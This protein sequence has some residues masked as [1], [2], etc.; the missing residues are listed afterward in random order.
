MKTFPSQ[1][2]STHGVAL[3]IVLS[4]IV[5]LAALV[6][7]FMSSVM[8]ER[9]A[10]NVASGGIAARQISESTV[11]L[12]M[13]QIREATTQTNE[14]VT[15]ASQPGAIRTFGN[16]IGIKKG[17]SFDY[18]PNINTDFVYKLYSSDRL[19]AP[20]SQYRGI[21]N[22][23]LSKEKAIINNWKRNDPAVGHVDLNE[24]LMMPMGGNLVEPR[25]PI[26]DPM[27]KANLNGDLK[28]SA[29]PGGFSAPADTSMGVVDGFDFKTVGNIDATLQMQVKNPKSGVTNTKPVAYLPMPVRWLYLRKDGSF[30]PQKDDGTIDG[31]SSLTDDTNPIVGRTAFWTDDESC[32]LNI[33]TASEGVFWDTPSVSSRYESGEL[34]TPQTQLQV[35]YLKNALDLGAI[36]PV[37]G[38]F[39]RY[40]GHP[41]TT[42]LSPVLGWLWLNNGAEA[43]HSYRDKNDLPYVAFKEAIY[44]ISPFAPIYRNINIITQ[45]GITRSRRTSRGGSLNVNKLDASFPDSLK[46]ENSNP[47]TQVPLLDTPTSHLYSDVDELLFNSKRFTGAGITTT[48][49]NPPAPN[50]FVPLTPSA[51]ERTRF[52]LTAN[53]RAPEVTLQGRPRVTIWPVYKDPAAPDD[54]SKQTTFDQLFAFTSTLR[55]GTN[56][57]LPFYFTRHNNKSMTDDFEKSSDNKRLFSYLR[58]ATSNRVPG[59]SSS[60]SKTFL[61]KY[62]PQKNRDQILVCIFDYIRTV[63]LVD[64]S[65]PTSGGGFNSYTK[66]FGEGLGNYSNVGYRSNNW[67]AQVAPTKIA[68]LGVQGQGRFP[69]LTE[70]ALVFTRVRKEVPVGTSYELRGDAL[71]AFIVLEMGTPTPGFPVIRE[72]FS[73]TLEE[74]SPTKIRFYDKT[75]P[76]PPFNAGFSSEPLVNI[77][78]VA[79]HEMG[80]GRGFRP[81]LG[82]VNGFYYYKDPNADASTAKLQPADWIQ[83]KEFYPPTGGTAEGH[84][85]KPNSNLSNMV[86]YYPYCTPLHTFPTLSNTPGDV[87]T[88]YKEA[89]ALKFGFSGGSY[90]LKIY[91]GYEQ[92]PENLV[93]TIEFA[94]PNT[95]AD[96]KFPI[97]PPSY[98]VGAGSATVESLFE[99][100]D[101]KGPTGGGVRNFQNSPEVTQNEARSIYGM[102]FLRTPG[103]SRSRLLIEAAYQHNPP[104][105]NT[106]YLEPTA[107]NHYLSRFDVVRGVEIVGGQAQTGMNSST[108]QGD[109]RQHMLNPEILAS[110]SQAVDPV[111]YKKGDIDTPNAPP[112]PSDPVEIDTST[113]FFHCHSLAFG[114]GRYLSFMSEPSAV[115]GENIMAKGW[116]SQ[117]GHFAK[118]GKIGGK[119]VPI[120][121][122]FADGVVRSDG[123]PGDFDRGLSKQFDAAGFNKVDEGTVAFDST[124]G[125]SNF[126]KTPY[127]RGRGIEEPGFSM[128]TPNRQLSSAVMFGSIPTRVWDTPGRSWETLLFRPDHDNHPGMLAGEIPDH[129][130]LDLFNMPVVEPYAISEPFSTAGKI[131]LNTVIAPFGYAD[132][133]SGTNFRTTT[134][135]SY[136]RRDTAL[137]GLIKSTK[138]MAVNTA[139]P[140]AGHDESG[141]VHGDELDTNP[142]IQN[143]NPGKFRWNIDLDRTI[144]EIETRIKSNQRGLFRSASEIC[145]VNLHPRTESEFSG[146]FYSKLQA[147]INWSNFWTTDY[148][149]TGDN[150]RERPYAHLYPRVT[151]KSNVYTVHMRCQSLKRN[152][153]TPG[154]RFDGDKDIVDGE[155]RG[156][157]TVERFIDPNDPNLSTYNFPASGEPDRI[158]PYYRMRVIST[159]QFSPR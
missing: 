88:D 32:K 141:F 110:H 150:M 25:Y 17:T 66:K 132:G 68:S 83:V 50:S 3:V 54:T 102:P 98:K 49:I 28:T 19:R 11:S 8:S 12:V 10:V 45:D 126:Y 5:L 143:T 125:N 4:A 101:T 115:V 42:S 47:N 92:T 123:M 94:F 13:A 36:Q 57:K 91:A 59:F 86:R 144:D 145:E 64:S 137:R 157:A 52:F 21:G 24:P 114:Y 43:D 113:N 152:K 56:D 44:S 134:P 27:A 37:R 20:A 103:T 93:Q 65:T 155:Y 78:N 124:A 55:S 74:T 81:D 38:E 63:N 76:T 108:K 146:G 111:R 1:H 106:G 67:A 70:A 69:T 148:A 39:Q 30:W 96:F 18:T 77:Y 104:S 127:Y 129:L 33:N 79:S 154:N 72:T 61:S 158:E 105:V 119:I 122:Y 41:A 109:M 29:P 22:D 149:E 31:F 151:T 133:D 159:K 136:L 46:A 26:I 142:A 34:A 135:R 84:P 99:L 147:P 35:K 51:L 71:Q 23:D 131:N 80:D 6:I 100:Y 75:A 121:P 112:N 140:Q 16:G 85:N 82:W 128:F 89:N 107:N 138:M 7:G 53:S 73:T 156:S 58:W 118:G 130:W 40:P 116:G 60:A 95:F 2:R 120:L 14:T 15:W 87:N 153:T 97:R 139:Q 117:L 62:G 48:E 9:R 90:K